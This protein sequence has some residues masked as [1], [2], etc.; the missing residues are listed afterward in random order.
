[1]SLMSLKRPLYTTEQINNMRKLVDTFVI[2]YVKAFI[3]TDRCDYCQIHNWKLEC[4]EEDGFS[5]RLMASCND[6][7]ALLKHY[8]LVEE[9]VGSKIRS[10][11]I[12]IGIG[13][14]NIN[15]SSM[16]DFSSFTMYFN[17]KIH[18]PFEGLLRGLDI[19]TK[20]N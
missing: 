2:P 11:F 18:I 19:S 14:Y 5:L 17:I 7:E 15:Y 1:M 3:T 6:I 10:I 20:S 8:N 4:I 16:P 13:V 9:D 12:K